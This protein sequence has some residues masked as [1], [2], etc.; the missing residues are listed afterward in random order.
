MEKLAY[1]QFSTDRSR[2]VIKGIMTKTR[3]KSSALNALATAGR[4]SLMFAAGFLM[5]FFIS[6]SMVMGDGEAPKITHIAADI[7][8]FTIKLLGISGNGSVFT[9]VLF[10]ADIVFIVLFIFILILGLVIS[11]SAESTDNQTNRNMAFISVAVYVAIVPFILYTNR[12]HK[13]SLTVEKQLALDFVKQNKKVMQEAGGRSTV[14]LNSFNTAQDEVVYYDISVYGEKTIYAIVEVSHASEIP[15]FT[16]ACTTSLGMG[17]RD[18][19]KH[20]CRQ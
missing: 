8:D 20:P 15:A 10:W 6:I 12:Q 5:F 2:W 1:G 14:V 11:N 17:S 18:P 13:T 9:V 16:L 7:L 19:Y 3:L 4:C